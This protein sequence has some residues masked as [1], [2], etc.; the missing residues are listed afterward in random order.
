MEVSMAAYSPLIHTNFM[1]F[2]VN[3]VSVDFKPKSRNLKRLR[4]FCHSS[5]LEVRD[6][7]YRPPGTQ[8]NILSNISFCLPQKSFGLI[9]GRSGSGKTTLL[10]LLA[11]L[12]KPTSGSILLQ[13][14][15]EDRFPTEPP[16]LL[17]PQRVGI[18]FQFPERCAMLLD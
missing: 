6:L 7:C 1:C 3:P 17:A 15:G 8:L 14:Y 16:E 10:Q 5:C 2:R 18:V 13:R 12:S 9:F 11:G 4:I